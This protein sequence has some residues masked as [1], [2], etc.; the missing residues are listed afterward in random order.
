M[1]GQA[2]AAAEPVAARV[3]AWAVAVRAMAAKAAEA[4][5]A[6]ARAEA[7]SPGVVSMAAVLVTVAVA[8]HR[9]LVAGSR[10]NLAS[11]ETR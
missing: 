2:R 8:S 7:A 6:M 4:T 9:W 10:R 11:S 1:M 5:R 3:E